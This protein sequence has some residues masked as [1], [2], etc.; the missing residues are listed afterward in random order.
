M[1]KILFAD[2]S[3]LI[4]ERIVPLLEGLGYEVEAVQDGQELLDRLEAV[5][6]RFDLVITDN[7]M[8]RL[9]GLDILR[10]LKADARFRQP[11]IVVYSTG[12]SI[13]ALV[14]LLGERFVDKCGSI[15]H[16][17]AAIDEACAKK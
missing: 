15:N 11:P 10:R 7:N 16:L 1:K 13:R 9:T 14:E 3:R 5:P 12:D 6:G 4:R 2:D 17:L 8:P